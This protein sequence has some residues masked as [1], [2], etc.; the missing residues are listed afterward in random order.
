MVNLFQ[1]GCNVKCH[2]NLGLN[3]FALS[4]PSPDQVLIG[5]IIP[6]GA[7]ERDGRLRVADELLCVDGVLVKGRSHRF[8]LEL[9]QNATRNN[10]VLLTVRRNLLPTG[11]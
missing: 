6:L 9:M 7:A 5:A 3:S 11:E 10:Q 2:V 4:T 1:S 8:V